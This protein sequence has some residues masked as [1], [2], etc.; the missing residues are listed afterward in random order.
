MRVFKMQASLG[1]SSLGVEVD[2]S[3]FRA[4]HFFGELR[5]CLLTSTHVYQRSQWSRFLHVSGSD[6]VLILALGEVSLRIFHEGQAFLAIIGEDDHLLLP[7]GC[8]FHI[9][10]PTH[11]PIDGRISHNPEGSMRPV[12]PLKILS[13]FLGTDTS[14][15]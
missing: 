1:K 3:P 13:D 7:E 10:P 12:D 15:G 6:H 4:E 11:F 2:A 9:Q 8:L 5:E 14:K